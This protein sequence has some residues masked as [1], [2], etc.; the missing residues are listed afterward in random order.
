MSDTMSDSFT[1][2]ASKLLD[3]V[4]PRVDMSG[5]KSLIHSE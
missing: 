3:T 2:E 5:P 1:T 4:F